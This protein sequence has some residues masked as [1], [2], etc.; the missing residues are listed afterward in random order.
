MRIHPVKCNPDHTPGLQ[1]AILEF[2]LEAT[3]IVNLGVVKEKEK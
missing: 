3:R 2:F 1:V